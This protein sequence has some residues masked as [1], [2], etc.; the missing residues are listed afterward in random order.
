MHQRIREIAQQH[1]VSRLARGR[2]GVAFD[3]RRETPA[4]ENGQDQRLVS[5]HGITAAKRLPA[6]ELRG[7]AQSLFDAQQLIVFRDAVGAAGRSGLDLARV[8][9]HREIGNERIFGLA[10]TMRNHRRVAVLERHLHAIQRFGQ[11]ADLIDFDQNRI[12]H[13]HLDALR[14]GAR[15]W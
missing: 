12:R 2:D 4:I 10:R 5:W 13:A 15:C 9:G 7:V 11:R 14:S 1:V 8:G 6:R 3:G